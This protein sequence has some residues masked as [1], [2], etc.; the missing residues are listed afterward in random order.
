MS[1]KL[2]MGSIVAMTLISVA[3][4]RNLPNLAHDGPVFIWVLFLS[5]MFFLVP[6]VLAT[7]H[8]SSKHDQ[9]G[10]VYVWVKAVFSKNGHFWL[11]GCNG[12]RMC[13]IIQFC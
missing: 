8:L 9:S 4:I 13:F 7:A 1:Q 10:G 5:A 12:L 6:V 11:H 3:N 2:K